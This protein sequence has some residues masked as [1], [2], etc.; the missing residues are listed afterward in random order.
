MQF[1]FLRELT[2]SVLEFCNQTQSKKFG[3]VF[4][5]GGIRTEGL[6]TEL[7]NSL[8]NEISDERWNIRFAFLI[9]MSSLLKGMKT[10]GNLP[11]PEYQGL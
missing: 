7:F 1:N 8:N 9:F 2:C 10:A 4:L 5:L 3:Q 11:S 6:P